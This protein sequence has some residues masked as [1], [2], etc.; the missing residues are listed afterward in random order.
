MFW[1]QTFI[2]F[3]LW[4]LGPIFCL[5]SAFWLF[6]QCNRVQIYGGPLKP[7]S[8]HIL[9]IFVL[10]GFRFGEANHPR[11]AKAEADFCIGCFNPSGL[12]GKAQVIN[13]SLSYADLWAVSERQVPAIVPQ[14]FANVQIQV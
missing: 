11:P 2:C 1:L 8:I 9:F 5:C 6:F 10:L 12:T 13:E 3:V 4:L 7:K 14:K